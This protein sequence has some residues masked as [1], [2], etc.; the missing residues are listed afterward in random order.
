MEKQKSPEQS[1]Q[2]RISHQVDLIGGYLN[3]APIADGIIKIVTRK[4]QNSAPRLVE[5]LQRKL[6]AL[7]HR[8]EHANERKFGIIPVKPLTPEESEQLEA[9]SIVLDSLFPLTSTI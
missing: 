2:G 4:E 8:S 3:A 5:K 9:I 1:R 7:E 6:V